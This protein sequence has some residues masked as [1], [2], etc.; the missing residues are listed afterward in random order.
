MAN[1]SHTDNATLGIALIVVAM[2][3]ISIND[4]LIKQLAGGYPLHEIIFAR[5]TIGLI[6]CLILVAFDGGLSIL[7]TDKPFLHALR[8][9]L[10]VIANMT[11]F[12]AI[13]AIPLADATALFFVA[14]LFITLL[15]IPILG[16][17]VGGRR[18]VAVV[19]GFA[20]VLVM[21]Q[22]GSSMM[23]DANIMVALLPVVAA[24]AYA[25]TQILT[26]KLGISTKSSA[27]AVYIQLA[28]VAVSS[29]FWIACGDGR[30]AEGTANPSIEFLFR[31]WRWP[32]PQD[33][34][35]LGLLG[36]VSAV[37]SYT[38]S[39]AYKSANAATIAP[40]EYVELPMAIFWGW[41][42]W[43][44]FPGPM[45]GAGIALIAGSGIYVFL[46]EKQRKRPLAVKR[47]TRRW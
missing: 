34:W 15:S 42:F 10:I 35:L 7:R 16:E 1:A 21:L 27:L 11:Y 37:I 25:L 5:A 40:F 29:A 30:F 26:R 22:P 2:L 13:A 9:M 20:G 8:G 24:L 47:P 33:L 46:R 12:L 39:A 44:E 43:G 31:A 17:K 4:M 14:P 41:L 18:L 23:S 36:V 19:I 6:L 38:L 32:A 3:A 28:F 45:T